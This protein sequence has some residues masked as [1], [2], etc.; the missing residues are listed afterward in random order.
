MN[1]ISLKLRQI[2]QR[3]IKIILGCSIFITVT[4][5]ASNL[6]KSL[7]VMFTIETNSTT[8]SSPVDPKKPMLLNH[9]ALPVVVY[10]NNIATTATD[11][12]APISTLLN[13]NGFGIVIPAGG[14][15]NFL[16]NTQSVTLYY[17]QASPVL[18]NITNAGQSWIIRSSADLWTITPN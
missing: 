14:G 2:D 11:P 8:P 15:V 6:P 12:H 13:P 9:S 7:P 17:G 1:S 16:P 18:A 4:L 5:G 3:I 10:M